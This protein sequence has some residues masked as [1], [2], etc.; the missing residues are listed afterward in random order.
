MSDKKKDKKKSSRR[1]VVKYP[2]LNPSYNL[3]SRRDVLDNGLY[4]DGAKTNGKVVIPALDDETKRYLDTFNKEYYNAS[5]DSQYDYD[6]VHKCQVDEE[7]VMDIKGQIRVLKKERRKIFG[8]SPNTTT[9]DDRDLARHYS[10]QIEDMEE[11]LNKVHPRRSCEHANNK[12]NYDL[13]NYAKRSN[14]YDLVSWEEMTD[15]MLYEIDPEL[16]IQEDGDED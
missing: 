12:R 10:E 11:F 13:L 5:F 2:N 3:K 7:T 15:D 16:H 6:G 4:V 14:E 1:D 8:K 9:E